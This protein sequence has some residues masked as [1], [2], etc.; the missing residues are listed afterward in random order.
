MNCREFRDALD[1]WLIAPVGLIPYERGRQARRMRQHAARCGNCRRLF[2][3]WSLLDNSI[4]EMHRRPEPKP[5]FSDRVVAQM[6]AESRRSMTRRLAVAASAAAALLL[7]IVAQSPRSI[8]QPAAVAVAEPDLSAAIGDTSR[9]YLALAQNMGKAM[10]LSELSQPGLST[11]SDTGGLTTPA[12][13]RAVQQSTQMVMSA[14]KEVGA[15]I[16]PIALAAVGAFDFL[17]KDLVVAG[18]KPST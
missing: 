9:A 15:G 13:G 3:D 16:R 1:E 14:S 18:E 17:W 8:E 10:Q 4:R 2:D 5:G 6:R 12:V 7:A 11:S